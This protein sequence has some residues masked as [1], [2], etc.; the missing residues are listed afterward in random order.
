MKMKAKLLQWVNV[1]TDDPLSTG[2]L[3]DVKEQF[4]L[5]GQVHKF[6]SL[7]TATTGSP[8]NVRGLVKPAGITLHRDSHNNL[9]LFLHDY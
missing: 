3:T 1:L 5:M 9:T 8:Q 6:N 7:S 4:L 2:S